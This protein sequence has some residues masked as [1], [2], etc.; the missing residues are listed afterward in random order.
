MNRAQ[1]VRLAIQH[2]VAKP[3]SYVGANFKPHAWVVSAILE[4]SEG[5]EAQ[6]VEF[7][8]S[9]DG[10][11]LSQEGDD[12]LRSPT[13]Q[14]IHSMRELLRVR[15][16]IERTRRR[17]KVPAA[18][19]EECGEGHKFYRETGGTTGCPV[20]LTMERDKLRSKLQRV[21]GSVVNLSHELR[22]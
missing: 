9:P 8:R 16:G 1:A 20:C 12:A 4:A 2:A 19:L 6:L 14:A 17:G 18:V 13:V 10:A 22:E 5:S 7:F 21:R 15:Q 3:E 11:P